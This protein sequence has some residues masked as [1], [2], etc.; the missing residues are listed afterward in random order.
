MTAVTKV[1]A[2]TFAGEVIES[3][4]PVLV[5]FWAQWCGPCRMLAPMLEDIAHRHQ[6]S[7]AVVKVDIDECAD[8]AARYQVMSVP[9]LMVFVGGKVVKTVLGAKP[10][11][12]LLREI[13]DYV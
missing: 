8:I 13:S 3:A 6:E 7:L 10:K 2:D 1:D 11:S 9:T 4:K 5:D 12:V